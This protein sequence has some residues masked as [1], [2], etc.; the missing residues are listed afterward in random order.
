MV[1]SAKSGTALQKRQSRI[2]VG[3]LVAAVIVASLASVAPSMGQA[4]SQ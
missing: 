3:Q 4:R 1:N 2:C